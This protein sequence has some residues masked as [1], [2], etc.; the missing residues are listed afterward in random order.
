MSLINSNYINM[1]YLLKIMQI[2]YPGMHKKFNKNTFS[3]D[4]TFL[5]FWKFFNPLSIFE[6]AV[7][8]VTFFF[9]YKIEIEV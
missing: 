4:L 1:S 3:M 5:D 6:L 8:S 9:T 7:F 2:S